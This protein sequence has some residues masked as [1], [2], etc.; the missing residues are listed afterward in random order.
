MRSS[1]HAKVVAFAMLVAMAT[2]ALAQPRFDLSRYEQPCREAAVA[3]MKAM[4]AA[5]GKALR[6]LIYYDTR[7]GTAQGDGVN[8]L[9]ECVLAQRTFDGALGERF[10]AAA[11]AAGNEN[12]RFSQ[13]DYDA[14]AQA[15]FELRGSDEG[16]LIL[17]PTMAPITLQRTNNR[18]N[19]RI[20][21]RPVVTLYNNSRGVPEPGSQ[22]RIDDM[23][24]AART[25]AEVTTQVRSGAFATPEAAVAGLH[26]AMER[27]AAA[28][29]A[30]K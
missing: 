16:F 4:D 14:V 18:T 25:L 20:A 26:A 27:A 7:G 10:G 15:R 3:F 5:D 8:A 30:A 12:G 21:L 9:V 29:P 19:W 1:T 22:R 17:G 6:N 24:T 2:P 11:A 13:A 23:L 28:A